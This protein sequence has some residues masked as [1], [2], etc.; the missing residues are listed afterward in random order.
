[1]NHTL[2]V[3][4]DAVLRGV[5][6]L[7]ALVSLC[8]PGQLTAK[9]RPNVSLP[10]VTEP[11]QAADLASEQAAPVVRQ[12][13]DWVM[14]SGNH[15]G[16]PF[17]ILD[18]QHA[19]LFVFHPN[20]KL[21][22]ASAALLGSARG[23]DSVPGIGER[24]MSAIRP[25]ERTT[26]AGRFESSPGLNMSGE[27]IVWVD[28]EAAVSMHRVRANNKKERRLERLASATPDDN[29]IS[30]GC[31]NLPAIFYDTVLKPAL[32]ASPGVVYVLPETRSLQSVFGAKAPASRP[33]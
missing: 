18:K 12:M 23:D 25:Q 14:A 13:A 33:L 3:R 7:F 4:A 9:D 8:L 2:S 31:I 15:A 22:G 32:G 6:L 17:V 20:G 29:R 21:R 27:D 24:P 5:G 16:M 30:F 10:A 11:V 26:P 28:Y 1:M 19:K